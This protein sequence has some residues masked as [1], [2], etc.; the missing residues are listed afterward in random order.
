MRRIVDIKVID[1]DLTFDEM[2][3]PYY[4]LV[5]KLVYPPVGR[6]EVTPK[7]DV[8]AILMWDDTEKVTLN[9]IDE[10]LKHISGFCE[11]MEREK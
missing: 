10:K 8:R 11:R 5:Y 4:R 2:G 6:H 9:T 1:G 3:E 7:H